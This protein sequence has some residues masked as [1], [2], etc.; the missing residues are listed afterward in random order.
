MSTDKMNEEYFKNL[1]YELRWRRLPEPDVAL[2]L[3][4]VHAESEAAQSTPAE[5][6]GPEKSYA[7]SFTKGK[8]TSKGYWIISIA[9]AI[10]ALLVLARIIFSFVTT[11]PSNPLFSILNLVGALAIIFIGSIIG[12]MVDHRI[13]QGVE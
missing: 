8:T 5:L 11:A 9:V 2:A 4:E 13:P 6:F 12:S 7:E 3:R 1:A 10:A